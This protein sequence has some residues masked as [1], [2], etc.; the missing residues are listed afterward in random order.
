MHSGAAALTMKT[1]LGINLH[2][3]PQQWVIFSLHC[4]YV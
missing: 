4:V 2:F 1:E 3:A